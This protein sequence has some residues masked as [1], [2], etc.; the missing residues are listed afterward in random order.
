M[1]KFIR[2]HMRCAY[3]VTIHLSGIVSPEVIF[4]TTRL[5]VCLPL[6]PISAHLFSFCLFIHHQF[7]QHPLIATPLHSSSTLTPTIFLLYHPY[8]NPMAN[9]LHPFASPT[10]SM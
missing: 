4:S 9:P 2:L 10:S 6:K 8:C 1:R 5:V 3:S 7:P